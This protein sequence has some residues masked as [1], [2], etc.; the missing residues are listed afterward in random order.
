[1]TSKPTR[2]D[3]TII[4]RINALE[5]AEINRHAR[6]AGMSLSRYLRDRGLQNTQKDRYKEPL[7]IAHA[8][9]VALIRR[10]YQAQGNNFESDC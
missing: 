7:A 6:S 9:N 2:K 8:G 1:M 5:L 4:L 10:E 3:K